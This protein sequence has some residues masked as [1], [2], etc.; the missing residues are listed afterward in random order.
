MTKCETP[1]QAVSCGV[2]SYST[3]DCGSSG[4]YVC[5]NGVCNAPPQCSDGIDNDG[6][7]CTDFNPPAGISPDDGCMGPYDNSESPAVC[8]E[9]VTG[10]LLGNG[11]TSAACPAE[12]DIIPAGC[13]QRYPDYPACC[14]KAGY[15]YDPIEKACADRYKRCYIQSC[16]DDTSNPLACYD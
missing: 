8:C 2:W 14:C 1:Q 4:S 5:R 10:G 12:G 11:C 7:G 3:F 13:S 15:R 9:K 6:D 16:F